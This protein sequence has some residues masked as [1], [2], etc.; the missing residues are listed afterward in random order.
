MEELHNEYGPIVRINPH[1]LHVR[2]P[3]FFDTVYAGPG[4]KRDRDPWHTAGL[5]LEGSV[6]DSPLHELHRKR[7]AALSPFFSKAYTQKMLPI[8][9]E[10]IDVLIERLVALKNSGT[11]VNFLY[12][13]SAFSNGKNNTLPYTCAPY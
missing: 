3:D 7:R 11:P 8:V 9:Q 2:D 6:L 5:A 13:L 12:A 10:R 4:H 1:E